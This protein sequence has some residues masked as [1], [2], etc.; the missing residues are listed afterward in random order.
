MTAEFLQISIRIPIEFDSYLVGIP[1]IKANYFMSFASHLS[2]LEY[3]E[4]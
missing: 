2:I 4:V 1:T 3:D